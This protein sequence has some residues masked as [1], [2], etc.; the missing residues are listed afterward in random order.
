MNYQ[1]S[2]TFV[3][4]AGTRMIEQGT[5]GLSRG[6]LLEGVMQGNS[7]F[8]YIPLNES[9]LIRHPP[10][11]SWIRSWSEGHFHESLEILKEEDWI[12]RGQDIDGIRRN[13]DGYKMPSYKSGTFL[14]EP[15]P[16]A[17][18]FAIESLRQG[19]HK[20]QDSFHIW[21][22]PRLLTGEWRR[23]MLKAADFVVDLPVGHVCW[24]KEMHEP[25][26]LA[27]FFPYLSSKP[28]E[29]RRCKFM[30]DM[31]GKLR[32][33]LKD[34]GSSGRSVLSKFCRDTSR[35]D[36]LPLR[37]LRGVLSGRKE[38]SLPN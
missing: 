22:V 3:H 27:F 37:E 16:A 6:D 11:E 15:A 36:S 10:L 19:R 18:L 25:L 8:K 35:L 5:D 32:C 26:T 38:P 34:G 17:A 28:W 31:E 1:C 12:W 23:N 14:W 33:L 2:I 4:V 29:L 30:V 21:I 24:P 20:R 7:I 13:I 9:A